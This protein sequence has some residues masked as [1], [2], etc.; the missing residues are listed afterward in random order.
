MKPRILISCSRDGGKNYSAAIEAAGGE[1]CMF[2]LPPADDSY[3]ALL[4]CG[5]EDVDPKYFGQ[6]NNGSEE[7]DLDRD[8]AELALMEKYVAAGKPILAAADGEI[9]DV[10]ARSGCGFCA[11]AGDAAG[12]A[13]AAERFLACQDKDK[14]GERARQYYTEHFTRTMFMDRLERVLKEHGT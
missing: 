3:D 1:P 12:L 9:P 7:P 13:A 8:E 11:G 14:L 2:Y 10:I 6:E 4:L 5:G